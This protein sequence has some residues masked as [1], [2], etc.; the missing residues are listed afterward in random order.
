MDDLEQIIHDLRVVNTQA[1]RL[2]QHLKFKAH[3][4]L[5][6]LLHAWELA[7]AVRADLDSMGTE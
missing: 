5:D 6:K 7:V 1:K 2:P 4:E 3:A